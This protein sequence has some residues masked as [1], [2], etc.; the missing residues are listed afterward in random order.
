[1]QPAGCLPHSGA[2][3]PPQSGHVPAGSC[4]CQSQRFGP[5]LRDWGMRVSSQDGCSKTLSMPVALSLLRRPFRIGT[6]RLPPHRAQAP[7]V[8]VLRCSGMRSREVLRQSAGVLRV[9]RLCRTQNA[10]R[11]SIRRENS[12]EQSDGEERRPVAASGLHSWR[13]SSLAS[14]PHPSVLAHGCPSLLSVAVTD[15]GW[16]WPTRAR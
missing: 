6:E 16:A 4:P 11:Q 2:H 5:I 1:M 13:C 8:L 14:V 7:D 10:V 15:W 12:I 3:C 9:P